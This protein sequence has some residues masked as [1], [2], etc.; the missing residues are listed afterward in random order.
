MS[1]LKPF[2]LERALAGDKVVDNMG[3][4]YID[5]HLF[6]E[7]KYDNRSLVC[8]DKIHGQYNFFYE[9]GSTGENEPFLFMAPKTKTYWINI[10]RSNKLENDIFFPKFTQGSILEH[11]EALIEEIERVS[12]KLKKT[13]SFEI[14]E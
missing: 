11:Q 3:C 6:T 12:L 2:N 13:I 5:F 4:E 9:N 8:I 10:Y 1:N 7:M 14:E